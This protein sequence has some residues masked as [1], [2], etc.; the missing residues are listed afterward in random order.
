MLNF[1]EWGQKSTFFQ[2]NKSSPMLNLFLATKHWI[3]GTSNDVI[4]KRITLSTFGKYG[5]FNPYKY[6]SLT[7]REVMKIFY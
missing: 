4:T 1:F 5:H 6:N 7:A 2:K 3:S